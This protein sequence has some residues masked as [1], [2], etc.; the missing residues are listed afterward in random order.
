MRRKIFVGDIKMLG[1]A[2]PEVYNLIRH[3]KSL[4]DSTDVCISV[5]SVRLEYSCVF[6]LRA[7]SVTYWSVPQNILHTTAH[8]PTHPL[9]GCNLNL[10][11][12]YMSPN[13]LPNIRMSPW[14][15]DARPADR[16]IP[17]FWC[18]LFITV[19]IKAPHNTI[20]WKPN[21]VRTVFTTLKLSSDVWRSTTAVSHLKVFQVMF[22]M[23][24]SSS[25]RMLHDPSVLCLTI[26]LQ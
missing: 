4:S 19:F 12:K 22:C 5:S 16:T 20:P 13:P 8:R 23:H 7:I 15:A 6:L 26:L 24:L 3:R 25:P 2:C 10:D 17:R 14:Q 9:K 11:L 1:F 18:N 21:L